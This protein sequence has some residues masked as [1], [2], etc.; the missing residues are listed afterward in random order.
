MKNIFAFLCLFLPIFSASAINAVFNYCAYN[1]PQSKPYIETQLLIEGTSVSYTPLNQQNQFIAKIAVT[2]LIKQ[3][4]KIVQFD[5]YNLESPTAADTSN[6]LFNIVSIKRYSLPTG[7]YTIE[8]ELQ[9]ITKPS[10][11]KQISQNIEIDF[12]NYQVSLS[13]ILLIESYQPIQKDSELSKNGFDIIP[14]IS[15]YY[16]STVNTLPFYVEVNTPKILLDSTT[17]LVAIYSIKYFNKNEVVNN[18]QSYKK[19]SP[20]AISP[21]LGEFNIE[22]LPSGNYMLALEVKDKKGSTLVQRAAFFQR[23]NKNLP[24]PTPNTQVLQ[25]ISLENTFV[26]KLSQNEI[27]F[28]TRSLN[29]ICSDVQKNQLKNVI[30]SK[31]NLKISNYLYN[32]W[33]EKDPNK[34]ET[35]FNNYKQMVDY[36]QNQYKCQLYDGFESDLGRVYLTYGPPNDLISKE[37][38]PYLKPYKIWQYYNLSNTKQSNVLFVFASYT[39]ADN[40]YELIHSNAKGEKYNTNWKKQL[41]SSTSVQEIEKNDKSNLFKFNGTDV[42]IFDDKLIIDEK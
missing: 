12:S 38:E 6:I 4:E 29:P 26:S 17:K 14:N 36:V 21:L 1:T 5:K 33:I 28:Y 20:A 16:P 37:H 27:L 22:K 24:E 2:M 23:N 35:A 13:D 40:C 7:N 42:N 11:S 31:D 39:L 30:S 32:F 15:G 10:N 9:D 25:N 41:A 34:P 3:N 18:M 19:L 8:F